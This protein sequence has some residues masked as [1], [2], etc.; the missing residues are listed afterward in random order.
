MLNI[1]QIHSSYSANSY[2]GENI[3]VEKLEELLSKN[4]SSYSLSI[5]TDILLRNIKDRYIQGLKYLFE[6]NSHILESI[7]NADLVI[8]HN[9][10]PYISRETLSFIL[11]NTKVLKVWHNARPN[12][13]AGGFYRG[14]GTCTACLDSKFGKFSSVINRCYRQSRVQSAVVQTVEQKMTSLYKHPNMY[15]LAISEYIKDQIMT[16]GISEEKIFSIANFSRKFTVIP[17]HGRDYIFVGRLDNAKGS[18]ELITAWSLL[19]SQDKVGRKLH[20]VGSSISQNWS[21]KVQQLVSSVENGI[22]IHGEL[23]HPEINLLSLKCRTSVVP[24]QWEEA[25]GNV[26]IEALSMGLRLIVTPSGA[27]S[28]L[29]GFPGVTVAEDKSSEAILAA[30]RKDLSSPAIS[31]ITISNDWYLNFSSEIIEKKWSSA[32][33]KIISN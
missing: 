17:E 8:L 1:V 33:H 32:I 23:S 19:P 6:E 30:I 24:S 26:S 4:F 7:E 31:P 21:E 13:I 10:I 28:S 3:Y 2:S 27:L 22:V 9:T 18:A 20:L 29:R 25:F 16:F 5:P 15:H 14:N 12:C 11:K